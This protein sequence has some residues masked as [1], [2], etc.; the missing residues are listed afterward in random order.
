MT[1]SRAPLA[2]AV[3]L[4]LVL[5]ADL[6]VV[7]QRRADEE[8]S[9]VVSVGDTSPSP[10]PPAQPTLFPTPSPTPAREPG[11][12]GRLVAPPWP[13]VPDSIADTGPLDLA[14][15]AKLDGEGAKSHKFLRELGFRAAHIR[16]WAIVGD[17]KFLTT[18]LYEFATP[19]GATDFAAGVYL[20]RS[21]EAQ[22]TER[23]SPA[24]VRTLRD[25]P[26]ESGDVLRYAIYARGTRVALV[27]LLTDDPAPADALAVWR[28]TM[29]AQARAI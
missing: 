13:Q 10:S 24:G 25:K 20:A 22:P 3:V 21:Q 14:G 11:L 15:A 27:T 2:L 19:K 5:G 1:T 6:L 12:A 17:N 8:A 4:G 18:L 29:A 28:S 16:A 23:L 7:A 9:P 26:D